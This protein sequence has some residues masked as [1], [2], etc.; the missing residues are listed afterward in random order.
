MRLSEDA[1]AV[2]LGIFIFT[3][4]L[5]TV[6]GADLMGWA[7]NTAVWTHLPGALGPVSRAWTGIPG[8]ACLLA[9]FAFLLVTLTLGAAALGG[10]PRRFAAAF[11]LVFI[12]SYAAWIAVSWAYIA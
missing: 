4:S 5:G 2:Y 10:N 11:T 8:I 9:T 1:L 6:F 12:C 7:V 3:I